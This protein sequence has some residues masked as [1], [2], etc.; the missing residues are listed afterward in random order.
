MI[1]VCGLDLAAGRGTTELVT[2][3]SPD[4]EAPPFYQPE[5]YQRV[6]DDEAILAALV[7]AGPRVVAIDAPLTLPVAVLAALTGAALT[8]AGSL[9]TSPYTRAAERDA[10]WATLGVRPLPVSFLGGLTFRALVLR[11]R[12]AVTL[13]EVTV[14]ETFPAAVLRALGIQAPAGGGTRGAKR[15]AK[16]TP[17]ARTETQWGL[18]RWITGIPA[19]D[20]APL[21][22][23]L[24]DALAAAL[25]AVA[26]LRGASQAIGDANEGQII[27]PVRE[28]LARAL[29][30]AENG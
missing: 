11:A 18:G 25:A 10:V 12:L 16:T 21:G 15:E 3:A 13:P 20:P 1:A 4:G 19:P 24:L 22:A 6:G 29:G 23:D 14:I 7:A 2:L 9:Y 17:A 8:G 27:L 30:L 28:P 5:T 26:Y